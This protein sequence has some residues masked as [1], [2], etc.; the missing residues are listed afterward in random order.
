MSAQR[1]R[2]CPWGWEAAQPESGPQPVGS[3]TRPC[4]CLPCRLPWITGFLA[5]KYCLGIHGVL[6]PESSSSWASRTNYHRWGGGKA[7]KQQKISDHNS[8]I[9]NPRARHP[10]IWCLVRTRVLVHG[11]HLFPVSWQARGVM[12]PPGPSF[13]RTLIPFREPHPHYL[14]TSQRSP[15]SPKYHHIGHSDFNL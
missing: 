7:Y 9:G 2:P 1:Q 12:E 14:I 11:L 8:E 3:P 6:D 10:Q 5:A 4:R 15:S 13:T